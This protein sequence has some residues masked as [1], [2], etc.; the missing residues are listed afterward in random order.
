MSWIETIGPEQA[1]S[2]LARSYQRLARG[3][4]LDNVLLVHSLRPHTLDGH[5]ALYRSVLHHPRNRLDRAFAEAIG[6]RVSQLNGCRYCVAHHAAGMG[7]A[8]ADPVR[9]QAWLDAL[10]SGE[11]ESTFDA[12]QCAALAYVERLTAVPAQIAQPDIEALRAAGWSDGEIL[13]I[14]QVAAYFAYANR[15]VL[16]LGVALEQQAAEQDSPG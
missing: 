2:E 15:T 1:Q 9:T 16:G 12:A 10:D 5:L 4:A 14:N 3:G 6:V 11:F 8:L 7:R 13:E